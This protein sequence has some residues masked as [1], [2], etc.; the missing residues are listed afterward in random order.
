MTV[1]S[2]IYGDLADELT[3]DTSTLTGGYDSIGVLEENPVQIVFD[4]QSNVAV[5]ISN[6]GTSTWHTFPAG[7]ALVLDMRAAHGIAA[8]YTFKKG[9][10]FF[11]QG[12]AGVGIF[13]ISY[14][15][16]RA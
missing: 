6:N 13:S 16:A 14:T 5:E 2:S 12:S 8:N 15:F 11:A 9:M 4:N 3:I 10:E 1:N 7:E